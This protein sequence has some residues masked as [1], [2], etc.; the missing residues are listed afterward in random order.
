MNQINSK[1]IKYEEELKR[2]VISFYE[3]YYRGERLQLYSYLDT[4]FQ[5][6]VPLNYF[7]IHSDYYMDLGKLIQINSVDI[8]RENKI[9]LIEGVIAV[10]KKRKEVVFVLKSDYGGWKLAGDVIF[11]REFA[12]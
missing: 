6:D 11:H 5:R 7:L 12:R 9:A 10:G 4:A 2:I 3:S 8:Q 1:N